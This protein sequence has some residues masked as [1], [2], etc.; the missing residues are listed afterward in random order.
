MVKKSGMIDVGGKDVTRRIAK[1]TG[2]IKMEQSIIRKIKNGDIPKGNVLETARVAGIMAA[3]KT[4]ET[5]PLCHNIPIDSVQL[6]FKTG[7]SSISNRR[8]HQHDD[9][10]NRFVSQ[11]EAT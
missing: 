3:K 2:T 4:A 9:A 8:E 1:A 6:D 7:K 11:S 5:L 10:K